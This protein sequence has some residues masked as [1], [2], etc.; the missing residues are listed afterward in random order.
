M[1][2]GKLKQRKKELIRYLEKT[3]DYKAETIRF[4]EDLELKY[5]KGEILDSEFYY[6]LNK[7]L[8]NKSLRDWIDYYDNLISQYNKELNQI[9]N[10]LRENESI[11][12]NAKTVLIVLIFVM[13]SITAVIFFKSEITGLTIYQQGE[14]I[15][16]TITLNI[17][18]N[19]IIN[20]SIVKVNLNSQEKILSLNNFNIELNLATIDLS[21]FNLLA[22]NGTLITQIIFNNS[23]I[24]ETSLVIETQVIQP[25]PPENITGLSNIKFDRNLDCARCGQHKAPSNAVVNMT[26]KTTFEG[27]TNNNELIDYYP[28]SW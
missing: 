15:N 27:T 16:D 13:L 8:K 7:A 20:E 14:I 23:I 24:N 3:R 9:N 25:A 18:A 12:F 19:L 11:V 5:S 2:L 26:I 22:E 17:P 1:Q 10:E 4:V 28:I 6:K 21:K